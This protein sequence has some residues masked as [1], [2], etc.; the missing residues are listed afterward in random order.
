M[1]EFKR[2]IM[3]L[4][5]V[6]QNKNLSE[7]G[8][9]RLIHSHEA[10]LNRLNYFLDRT[11]LMGAPLNRIQVDMVQIHLLSKDDAVVS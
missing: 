3:I 4:R 7:I 2:I 5:G 10:H 9:I 11:F 8:C 1:H 6:F